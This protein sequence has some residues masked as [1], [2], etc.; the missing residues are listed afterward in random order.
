MGSHL[1]P[2]AKPGLVALFGS[3]ETS[4]SG[5]KIF[6]AIFRQLPSQP[7]VALLETPA[8]FELNSDRVIGRVGEFLKVHL[9]NYHPEVII[10]PARARGSEF[11]P[12][13][14]QLVE[15]MCTADLIF[16]GPGSPTY[17]VRQLEGSL[18]WEVLLACHQSGVAIALSSAAVIAVSA[19]SLPVYEIYKVGE[20]LHWKPGLDLLSRYGF[21][22]VFIPHWNNNEGG[23]EL[24]TSRCFMGETRFVR[25]VEL[26]SPDLTIIGID[27]NTGLLIDPQTGDCQVVGSGSVTL[28]HTGHIHPSALPLEEL[29]RNRFQRG[30]CFSLTRSRTLSPPSEGARLPA[31]A[32]QKIIAGRRV[33]AKKP[34][35]TAEVLELLEERQ[36]ARLRKDWPAADAIRLRLLELGWQVKDTPD[37]PQLAP[38]LDISPSIR[39][40]E[41]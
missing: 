9:R 3:G 21:S 32:W 11:S 6:D 16:M 13:N 27:E 24:D 37:G 30:Q 10:I 8:G 19:Y 35:P 25:L 5:Q 2:P 36:A 41:S 31:E 14:P 20:D 33:A 7:R 39:R 34:E 18:L 38:I 12:D 40:A 15:R 22:L 26:L 28:I 17:A 1:Y 29:E 4:S 23:D